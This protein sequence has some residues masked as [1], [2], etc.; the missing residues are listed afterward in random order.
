MT[1]LNIKIPCLIDDMNNT[2]ARAYKAWPDRLYVVAKD[3]TIAYRG[4]SGPIGFLPQ[5]MES[6]LKKELARSD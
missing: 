5:R 4:G 3:G 6:A 2:A 1:K